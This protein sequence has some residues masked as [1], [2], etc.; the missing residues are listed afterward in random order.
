MA[1]STDR[2]ILF[3]KDDNPLGDIGPD[4]LFVGLPM[5]ER[6]NGEHTLTITTCR[7]IAVGTRV[8]TQDGTG[9]WHEWVVNKPD[10][11]HDKGEHAI[12]TYGCI[13]SLQYDLTG[14]HASEHAEPGMGSACSG[15]AALACAL[16]GQGR[17]GV[18]TVDVPD[19]AAG[20]GCVMIADSGWERIDKVATAWKGEIDAEIEVDA[21]G[22][23][24]RSVSLRTHIG[25]T[26]ITRR[27]DWGEDLANIRRVAEPGPY[28]CR[29]VP[30]GRGQTEYAEDDETTF[31]WPI[32]ITEETEH[33][34][35]YIQDD[36]SALVFR[37]PDATAEDGWHYPTKIVHYDTDDP[38]ILL[39]MAE[40][41]KTN[42]TRPKVTYEGDVVQLEQAGMDP[43]GIVLGEEIQCADRGFNPD[44][45]LRV[46][47]RVVEW[48]VDLLA[49]RRNTHLVL[50]DYLQGVGSM[51]SRAISD[52]LGPMR[53]SLGEIRAG[54]AIVYLE[55]LVDQLNAEINAMGGYFYAVPGIGARTY[56][57][58]VS[59]PAVGAEAT[60][61][62]EMRGGAIRFADS[63]TPSGDWDWETLIVS[64]HIA[65][66]LVTTVQI[67]A[68]TI[69][70]ADHSFFIDLDNN[71]VSIGASASIGDTTVGEIVQDVEDAK[72]M[73]E[74]VP[75]IG[76]TST[77]G[78]VFKR[79]LG[80]STTIRVTI[81]TPGGNITDA[82]TL[83]ER[84]G[85]G[86]YLEWGW[87]DVKTGAEHVILV[88]D[89]RIGE[90][91]FTLTVSPRDIDTQAAITCSRNY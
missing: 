83:H 23:T 6:I 11:L 66:G 58:Q 52:A 8:L 36:E 63:R 4:E 18:G 42:H 15:S 24:S 5:F 9:K 45:A 70:S 90:N 34:E 48:T 78:M 44:A 30:Y 7:K 25:P 82:T 68:G 91:G 10:E 47:A 76:L 12:G 80:I 60:K 72:Q 27:F 41:D 2:L 46:Q 73:A 14:V 61:V 77:N 37:V 38:E 22:V 64:G 40:E 43:K 20:L 56:D 16:D 81:F 79:N 59:D 26:A 75:I 49:P 69:Q 85:A 17:W 51:L 13:W 50:G 89:P 19:V 29:V 39:A 28:Y 53:Q 21:T 57:R 35:D 1:Y 32:D 87:R 33:G 84:F 55:T 54:G 65:A 31:E 88:T 74:D 86:A 71:V 67:T 3:D 62:V